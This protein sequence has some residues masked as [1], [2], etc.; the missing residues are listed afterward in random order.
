MTQ[1]LLKERFKD[2]PKQLFFAK[3]INFDFIAGTA[4]LA[5]IDEN[6]YFYDCMLL[7]GKPVGYNFGERYIPSFNPD[8]KEVS[9][10]MS[11][12]DIYCVA[13]YIGDY[14]NPVVVGFLFPN[15]T[16]L[17]IPEL[18]LY[19]FRHESDVIIMIRGDGTTEFYHP[20][21]SYIKFGEDD[22]NNVAGRELADGGLYPQTASD[23]RVRKSSDFNATKQMGFFMKMWSGQELTLDKDGTIN[24]LTGP[25]NLEIKKDGTVN[26]YA[27]QINFYKV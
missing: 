14:S 22:V 4:D 17:S 15:Q 8:D 3:V 6:I 5:A 7:C 26:L 9:Y 11:P 25:I 19:I 10:V 24:L 16:E 20:S 13:A 18:G 23:F 21:G 27:T 12:G 1:L 2:T